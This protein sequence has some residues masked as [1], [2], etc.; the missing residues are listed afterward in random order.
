MPNPR[1]G[2][3]RTAHKTTA[4]KPS[5]QAT[6]IT[7]PQEYVNSVSISA[8]GS[9][10]VAGTFFFPYAAGAKHSAADVSRD[11]RRHL[12]LEWIG[13]IALAR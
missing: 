13:Q 10:V 6:P 9:V 4:M 2:T 1:P 12:R 5:W 11:H 8:D 7:T 3:A